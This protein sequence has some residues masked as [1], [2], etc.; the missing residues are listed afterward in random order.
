MT[1]FIENVLS[2]GCVSDEE[3]LGANTHD[4]EKDFLLIENM[5]FLRRAISNPLFLLFTFS[6]AA[7]SGFNQLG[8]LFL[9]PRF[10][11]ARAAT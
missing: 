2:L 10:R 11:A 4:S 3:N 6:F 1:F 5:N 8:A 7:A 9:F